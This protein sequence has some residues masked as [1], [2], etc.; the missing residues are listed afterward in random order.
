MS[1]KK[2]A[3]KKSARS[4]KTCVID[5]GIRYCNDGLHIPFYRVYVTV[6]D[7]SNPDEPIF[8]QSLDGFLK[9]NADEPT[10]IACLDAPKSESPS[11]QTK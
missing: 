6:H 7:E 4:N 8:A 3:E 2:S 9:V 1:K 11:M 5:Q 10:I